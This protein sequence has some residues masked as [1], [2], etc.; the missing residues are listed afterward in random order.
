MALLATPM[1]D[2]HTYDKII[3]AQTNISCELIKAKFYVYF[4]RFLG[5]DGLI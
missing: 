2:D 5:S 3:L 4:S 1:F